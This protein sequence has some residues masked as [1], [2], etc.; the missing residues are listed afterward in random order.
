MDFGVGE[1]VF[2]SVR[3]SRVLPDVPGDEADWPSEQP[4]IRLEITKIESAVIPRKVIR[5]SWQSNK[6]FRFEV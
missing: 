4:L 5:I 1:T 3:A 2:L 6:E